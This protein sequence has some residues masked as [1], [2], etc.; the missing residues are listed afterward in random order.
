MLNY[1]C[2]HLPNVIF[3]SIL[4]NNV[5]N[6]IY[7]RIGAAQHG[8]VSGARRQG[9]SAASGDHGE[10]A[11][12]FAVDNFVTFVLHTLPVSDNLSIFLLRLT[13]NQE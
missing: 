6:F 9:E 13:R 11:S 4:A 2:R 1:I 8:V 10:G 5:N 12:P 7:T 3:H